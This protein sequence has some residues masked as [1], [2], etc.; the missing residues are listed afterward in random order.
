M[1]CDGGSQNFNS[2]RGDVLQSGI[3]LAKGE[4]FYKASNF[5]EVGV[6]K[7]W[8]LADK[9]TISVDLRGQFVLDQFEHIYAFNFTWRESFPLFEDY[10]KKRQSD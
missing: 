3:P 8:Q 1:H 2:A 10:F 7:T 6:N 4:P 9:V 5:W